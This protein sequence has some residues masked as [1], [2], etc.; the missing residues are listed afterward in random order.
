MSI[1]KF[2]RYSINASIDVEEPLDS[3]TLHDED[4]DVTLEE[5]TEWIEEE[6]MDILKEGYAYWDVDV[7]IIER[8]VDE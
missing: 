7:E 3:W 6:A 5:I 2:V 1:K 4:E 8:E